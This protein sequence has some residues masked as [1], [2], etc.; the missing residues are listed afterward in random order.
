MSGEQPSSIEREELGQL[1]QRVKVMNT[2]RCRMENEL[3]VQERIN[4]K[5]I[6]ALRRVRNRHQAEGNVSTVAV[7]DGVLLLCEANV[8]LRSD[9]MEKLARLCQVQM[10]LH[11][12]TEHEKQHIYFEGR[13]NVDES[14]IFT[15]L[16]QRS[17]APQQAYRVAPQPPVS[18]PAIVDA[19]ERGAAQ[20]ASSSSESEL[21]PTVR[22]NVTKLY[23]QLPFKIASSKAQQALREMAATLQSNARLLST[24]TDQMQFRVG[25]EGLLGNSEVTV[26]AER[27][28][29]LRAFQFSS[30][31]ASAPMIWGA[32]PG[33]RSLRAGTLSI[34]EYRVNLDAPIE[35]QVWA[36][37]EREDEDEKYLGSAECFATQLHLLAGTDRKLCLPL[38]FAANSG[39]RSVRAGS[40]NI[41]SPMMGVD[42]AS[43]PSGWERATAEDGAE[44]LREVSSAASRSS[45]GAAKSTAA[46]VEDILYVPRVRSDP[47]AIV[48]I[49]GRRFSVYA[50]HMLAIETKVATDGSTPT[51]ARKPQRVALRRRLMTGLSSSSTASA[52]DAKGDD[53]KDDEDDDDD[54]AVN[55]Q[56]SSAGSG[57]QTTTSPTYVV[58]TAWDWVNA[59]GRYVPF[60]PTDMK[61]LERVYRKEAV[62]P[63]LG[64]NLII[65]KI[66]TRRRGQ[67][68]VSANFGF[69]PHWEPRE[70]R[71]IRKRLVGD[72]DGDGR[73]SD[74]VLGNSM[75]DVDDDGEDIYEVYP[76][77]CPDGPSNIQW[78][79]RDAKQDPQIRCATLSKLVE[80]VTH[81]DNLP[82]KNSRAVLLLMYHSFTNGRRLLAKLI[83]RYFRPQPAN[84]TPSEL[85]NEQK[86]RKVLQL[87]V[88]QVVKEWMKSHYSDFED[89]PL[90]K[91]CMRE[92]LQLCDQGN[93]SRR[94]GQIGAML[95]TL[96]KGPRELQG[97]QLKLEKTVIPNI[98]AETYDFAATGNKDLDEEIARQLCLMAFEEFQSIRMR[99]VLN[100]VFYSK[101]TKHIQNMTLIFENMSYLV[102]FTIVSEAK[103]KQRAALIQ[104]FVNIAWTLAF[105]MQNY[106][107]AYSISCAIGSNSIFRMKRTKELLR[108]ATKEKLEDL[109][110][111]FRKGCANADYRKKL[112]LATEK[113]CLPMIGVTL[114]DL[115]FAAEGN[116]DQ[117]PGMV[118]MFKRSLMSRQVQQL[119]QFQQKPY[120]FEAVDFVQAHL[121]AGLKRMEDGKYDEK[122]LYNM[123]LVV[124]PRQGQG[125]KINSGWTL[126]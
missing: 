101:E 17:T 35:L 96:D 95:R 22:A 88:M 86:Q 80:I 37:K 57:T 20:K 82:P 90:L 91:T 1:I 5:M 72:D 54:G 89:D 117:I 125:A 9:A 84:C 2:E 68:E 25:L 119:Y 43:I 83:S 61:A 79:D 56:A 74:A 24:R 123:S 52:A 97:R 32:N 110:K 126:V 28:V 114:K 23:S 11:S 66:I 33:G 10:D 116:K 77:D 27:D 47:S 60:S 38:H 105:D 21:M 30:E 108:P 122:K 42:V 109:N 93:N 107:M 64:S 81:P 26:G 44:F 45:A 49:D 8:Q 118:N 7:I 50:A 19:K 58:K 13:L 121:R 102:Q 67:A 55:R 76:Y 34:L 6:E 92:F 98:T 63:P 4:A 115:V 111:L 29:I 78:G 103:M 16:R 87:R 65:S 59:K 36:D 48:V 12:L 40:S 75:G 85:L 73:D 124:E 46:K 15:Y 51:G 39:S 99:D 53:A 69:E 41:A 100:K 104:K 31:L 62:Y 106:H 18:S 112:G 71:R 70:A 3:L 113:P 120:V 14:D 94:S